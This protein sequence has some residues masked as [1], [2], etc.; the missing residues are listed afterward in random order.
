MILML[1]LS[2]NRE[3]STGWVAQML[4]SRLFQQRSLSITSA[5][6]NLGTPTPYWLAALTGNEARTTQ[7]FM[8]YSANLSLLPVFNP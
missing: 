1:V 7:S 8:D 6:T 2:L 3:W 4:E 5:L